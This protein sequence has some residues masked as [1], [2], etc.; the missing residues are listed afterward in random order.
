MKHRM[1][2]NEMKDKVSVIIPVYKAETYLS[3]CLDSVLA[4]TYE[5]IEV[6]LVDDGSPDR[7]PIICDKYAKD[8]SRVI[9][10]HKANGGASSA[11]NAGLDL[12][13]GKYICFVDSDDFLP[14]NSINDLVS[15]LDSNGADYAA[16]ICAIKE[17]GAF[18]NHINKDTVID[19]DG[20]PEELFKYITSSGSYSP[21]A[22]IYL[23]ESIQKNNIRFDENLKCSED[24]LFIRTYLKYCKKI[25]LV[26]KVVYEYTTANESSLSKKGYTEFCAY[27]AE[28]MKALESLCD[29]LKVEQHTKES[30]IY[31]RA[32]HGLYI[33]ILHYLNHWKSKDERKEYIRKSVETL[34]PWLDNYG[35]ITIKVKTID[36][37]TAKWWSEIKE[38]VRNR[39]F[40]KIYKTHLKTHYRN[41]LKNKAFG[42][43][44]KIIR[45]KNLI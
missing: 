2:A 28:K 8:D 30:F 6:I 10:L 32:I 27:Y 20:E 19:F 18:K 34:S 35:N 15:S 23:S 12:A 4:Q 36:N 21:Y 43:I 38:M 37:A 44:K 25:S 31:E 3:K 7:C 39:D 11:R 17:T 42:A 24:A 26:S 40:D 29:T 33:S 45:Q 41:T 14:Q 13:S 9:A 16:G 22:K 5:N 1:R